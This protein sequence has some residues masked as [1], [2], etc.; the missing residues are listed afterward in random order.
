MS[1]SFESLT[2]AHAKKLLVGDCLSQLQQLPDDFVQTCVT[3]PPYWAQRD[4]LTRQWF[5]ED[6]A[7]SHTEREW[8]GDTAVCLQ[9]R[10]WYG[11]LGLEPEP[12]EYVNHLVEIFR[13][14]R[15][16][17]RKDGTFFL[18]IGDTY[19]SES[20]DGYKVKDLVGIPW[21]VAFA[22]RKDGW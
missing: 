18:N 2:E 22:L 11:Q 9:C 16:V 7:C 19:A 13:E 4:Y 6:P 15:R 8:A 10:G 14:V 20:G 21:M 3:S 1:A 12:E 17:L 5:D